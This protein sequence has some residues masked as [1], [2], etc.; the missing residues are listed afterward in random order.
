MFDLLRLIITG[1]YVPDMHPAL[2]DEDSLLVD[3]A[4]FFR[5]LFTA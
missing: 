2:G 1:D 3:V 5:S 4:L